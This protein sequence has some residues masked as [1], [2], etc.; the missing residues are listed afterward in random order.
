MKSAPKDKLFQFAKTVIIP[1]LGIILGI[2][3]Q[4]WFLG[5][6][7]EI[8]L[9]HEGS[10]FLGSVNEEKDLDLKLTLDNT[11]IKNILKLTWVVRNTGNVHYKFEDFPELEVSDTYHIVSVKVRDCSESIE[12]RYH[13]KGVERIKIVRDQDSVRKN[14]FIFENLNYFNAKDFV[15]FDI[16]VINLKGDIDLASEKEKKRWNLICTY[17]GLN[18]ADIKKISKS[19]IDNQG[20]ENSKKPSFGFFEFLVL[21]ALINIFFILKSCYSRYKVESKKQLVRKLDVGALV[22][23]FRLVFVNKQNKGEESLEFKKDEIEQENNTLYVN[24]E[25]LLDSLD[26]KSKKYILSS[27]N[28]E[29]IRIVPIMLLIS[30]FNIQKTDQ[31]MSYV[32]KIK[33]IKSVLKKMQELYPRKSK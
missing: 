31:G 27:Y 23:T 4:K 12:H 25:N 6:N 1:L 26:E 28:L 19:E 33:T 22:D 14:D 2:Y 18:V 10:I 7:H 8:S 29:E 9:I 15:R 30:D 32:V 20:K 24:L 16:F 13:Q 17:P 5:D 3:L 21:I 11:E